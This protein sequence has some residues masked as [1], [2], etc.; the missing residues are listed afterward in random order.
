MPN[1]REQF[2]NAASEVY[3]SILTDFDAIH[4]SIGGPAQPNV[5]VGIAEGASVPVPNGT[6]NNMSEHLQPVLRPPF[7]S[8]IP[9]FDFWIPPF[10]L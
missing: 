3:Q 8:W 1:D 7:D 6:Q 2:V 9:P 10:D 4:N 5:S